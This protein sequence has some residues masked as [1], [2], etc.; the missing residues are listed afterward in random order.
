[1]AQLASAGHGG[2]TDLSE[3]IAGLRSIVDPL[4]RQ[5]GCI[6]EIA[7][8]PRLPRVALDRVVARQVVLNLAVATLERGAGQIRLGAEPA[9]AA[10]LLSLRLHA[11]APALP[12]PGR[13]EIAR[14][15]LESEGGIVELSTGDEEVVLTARLPAVRRT[16][17][18]VVDDNPDVSMVLRRYLEGA[19]FEV[20]TLDRGELA[21]ERARELRPAAIVLDVMMV[22]QDGWETLQQLKNHPETQETPVLVCSVLREPELA[23]FLGAA[24]L[25]PKPVSSPELLGA[26]ARLGL[27]P[28]TPEAAPPA[29][30]C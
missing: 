26:L 10:V 7:L 3:V 30:L 13:V 5:H 23:R 18:L 9:D 21:L 8:A 24:D 14:R 19:N 20:A 25:L 6:L 2:S 11:A 17:V 27:A 29:S 1:V 4:A 22:G 15:L 28:S 12:D 16:C